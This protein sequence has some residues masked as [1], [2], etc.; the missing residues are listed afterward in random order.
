MRAKNPGK[1]FGEIMSLLGKK[2]R[3]SKKYADAVGYKEEKSES[4]ADVRAI[5]GDDLDNVARKLDF[6]NLES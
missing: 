5:E 3:E 4:V 2:F 6:L 1:S